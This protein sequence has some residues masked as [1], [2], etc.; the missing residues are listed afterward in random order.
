MS[1]RSNRSRN[2][3]SGT[4]GSGSKKNRRNS[5]NKGGR[6]RG[7]T[8]K[9]GD[10]KKPSH[11]QTQEWGT[12]GFTPIRRDDN[13]CVNVSDLHRFDNTTI[14]L[15]DHGVDKLLGAGPVHGEYEVTVAEATSRAIDKVEDAGG[16]VTLNE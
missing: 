5:G 11:W 14:D 6:G 15:N 13:T 2:R 1:R 12:Q 4:H 7:G 9:K 8:G 3:G 10:S 16:T